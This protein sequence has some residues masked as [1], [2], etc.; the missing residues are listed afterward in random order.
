L[1]VSTAPASGE[2]A[3]QLINV[4]SAMRG[5]A[6]LNCVSGRAEILRKTFTVKAVKVLAE[7][8]AFF[9]YKYLC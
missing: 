1:D 8:V 9:S 3:Y 7:A 4:C 2:Y 5:F 6:M